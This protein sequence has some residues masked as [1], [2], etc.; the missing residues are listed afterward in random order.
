MYPLKKVKI[1]Y[2]FYSKAVVQSLGLVLLLETRG[3]QHAKLPCAS[4]Y[5]GTWSNSCPLSQ[6]YHPTIW[7]SVVSIYS[8]L[9]SFP[10]SGSVLMSRLFAS[11]GQ[12]IRASAS[13]LP[14][15]QFSSVAQSCLTLCNPMDCSTPA[16]LSF[17]ISLSLLKLMS[18]ELGMPT[19]HLLLCLTSS[20]C[21]QSFPA[22]GLFQMSQFF[23]SGGQSVGVSAPAS[24]LPK[25]IQHW[26]P[27]GWTDWISLH[28]KGLWRVFSNTTVQKRQFFGTQLSS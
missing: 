7:S 22:S 20:S 19:N 25:N 24:V 23:T 3:L 5:P 16:S 12:S 18:I 21:L 9:Q 10:A 1:E 8:C 28:S 6:W 17:T 13:V 4:P 11:G 2:K 14:I 26:S 15:N 27:L